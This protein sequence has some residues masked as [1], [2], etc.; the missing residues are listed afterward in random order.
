MLMGLSFNWE[1]FFLRAAVVSGPIKD[2]GYFL[3]S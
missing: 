3:F 1:A 2:Q